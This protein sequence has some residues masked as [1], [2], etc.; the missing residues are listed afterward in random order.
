MHVVRLGAATSPGSVANAGPGDVVRLHHDATRRHDWAAMAQAVMTAYTRGAEL[1]LV[2]TE[3]E[4]RGYSSLSQPGTE[5][6][7]FQVNGGAR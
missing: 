7:S 6:E 4:P 3:S 1:R 5:S 2:A